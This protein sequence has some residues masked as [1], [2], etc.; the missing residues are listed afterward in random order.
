MIVLKRKD[1]ARWQVSEKL[2]DAALCKAVKE[3]RAN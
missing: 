3:M 2:S 1:F